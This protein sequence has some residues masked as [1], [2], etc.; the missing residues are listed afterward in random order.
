M[1]GDY[2][3][4]APA[5]KTDERMLE[6]NHQGASS[7]FG[8]LLTAGLAALVM[9]YVSGSGK[10]AQPKRGRV[11]PRP[12]QETMKQPQQPKKSVAKKD[13][14]QPKDKKGNVSA[15]T[16]ITTLAGVGIEKT[17]TDAGKSESIE[18]PVRAPSPERTQLVRLS[19][20]T[21]GA[22]FE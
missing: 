6:R 12:V 1:V 15:V 2:S 14:T 22:Q 8:L 3:A 19:P 18:A 20:G 5:I 17:T 16:S 11:I 13:Q 4:I 10:R 9:K 7:P 21:F